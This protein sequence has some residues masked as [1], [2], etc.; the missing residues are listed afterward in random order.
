MSRV[1]VGMHRLGTGVQPHKLAGGEQADG[2]AV[3]GGRQGG[4]PQ[5]TMH[6]PQGKATGKTLRTPNKKGQEPGKN[7]AGQ[8]GQGDK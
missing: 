4:T 3:G 1:S 6:W 7:K 5:G 8:Y 2:M